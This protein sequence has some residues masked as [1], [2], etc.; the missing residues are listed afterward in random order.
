MKLAIGKKADL[1]YLAKIVRI[2]NFKQ[3]S[4]PEVTRLKCCTVD[5]FNIITGI[6]SPAG[7]YVYFPMMC[8]INPNFLSYANLYRHKEKNE[9][10]EKSG[11]F[12]DNGRVKA[13]ALKG[14]KSEGFIIDYQILENWIVS[15]TNKS[16]NISVGQEFDIV[17]DGDKS[18]WICK[19]YIIRQE[20]GGHSRNNTRYKVSEKLQDKVIPSQFRFHYTTLQYKKVPQFIGPTD[21]IHISTKIHGTSGISANVLVRKENTIKTKIFKYC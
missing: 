11:M 8:Q 21:I 20:Q 1:N 4:N 2:E 10:P 18:F 16:L 3:H 5:G 9:N 15:V 7:L 19:K 13:I 6:D 17:E 12:E 14:E